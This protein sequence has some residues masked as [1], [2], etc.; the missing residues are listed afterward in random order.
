MDR[1][2]LIGNYLTKSAQETLALGRLLAQTLHPLD[3][4]CLQGDLGAGKTT[5][6]KGMIASLTGVQPERVCSPTYTY[7][8]IYEGK[9]PVF[10]F[11]LYRLEGADD[12][13]SL[14]FEEYLYGEGVC[15]IEW[16]ERITS[17]IPTHAHQ[18]RLE[19]AG[20]EVRNVKTWKDTQ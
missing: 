13:L 7:L 6:I 18:I 16:S 15:C 11:D 9:C 12:F 5:L 4:V 1:G 3:V 20:E 10:H 17:L 14:G 19:Y 8:N 2:S